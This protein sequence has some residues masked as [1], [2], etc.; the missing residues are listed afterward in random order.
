[1]P[2]KTKLPQIPL[3][4]SWSTRVQYAIFQIIALGRHGSLAVVERF[5]HTLKVECTRRHLVS[6]RATPFR[7]D[8]PWFVVRSMRHRHV[9]PTAS[10]SGNS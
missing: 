5:I 1:M 10:T 8:L 9:L 6:L 3:P 4:K 2:S 7:R